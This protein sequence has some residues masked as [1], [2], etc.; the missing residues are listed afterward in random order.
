[1]KEATYN[2]DA[3]E[4]W[5]R[6]RPDERVLFRDLLKLVDGIVEGE[7]LE[8]SCPRQGQG[9]YVPT[10]KSKGYPTARPAEKE[11]RFRL[12]DRDP[13]DWWD[14]LSEKDRVFVMELGGLLR[15]LQRDPYEAVEFRR[16]P[17]RICVQHV[18]NFKKP[19]DAGRAAV[20]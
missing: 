18:V 1:M 19:V 9:H 3:G 12:T 14:G 17:G 15:K 6:R 20:N 4:W 7:V 8:V 2:R 11:E 16:V 10:L 13:D 5:E